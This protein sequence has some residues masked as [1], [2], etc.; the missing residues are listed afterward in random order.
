MIDLHSHILPRLCDGAQDLTTALA[1]AK[2]AVADGTTHLACTPHIYPPVYCNDKQGIMLAMNELQKELDQNNIPL[3]LVIGADVNLNPNVMRGL[4]QGIIPTLNGS[5]YFLLEPPH[6]IPVPDFVGQV[7][8]FLYAGYIPVITHPERLHWIGDHYNDFIEA[9]KRGAWLQITAGA[10]TG[11]FGSGAQKMAERFLKDGYV[12]VIAS[13]AH[14]TQKRP[15]VL[16]DG[17]A[18]ASRWLN[19]EAEVLRMVCDRPSAILANK[20]PEDVENVLALS[21]F[22][23]ALNQIELEQTTTI[24]QNAA[25]GW[26]G[27]FFKSFV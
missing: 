4:K 26:F 11:R 27:R 21:T 8:N 23:R 5:R 24:R 7:E 3:T 9:V 19:N 2:L 16:S 17:V 10:T 6:H 25:S 14:D 22:G 12:H 15:P 13:D 18:V 20:N 1:M